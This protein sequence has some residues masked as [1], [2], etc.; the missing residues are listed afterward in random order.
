MAAFSRKLITRY[1]DGDG[2][3]PKLLTRNPV[4]LTISTVMAINIAGYLAGHGDDHDYRK[5]PL[6]PPNAVFLSTATSSGYI[7]NDAGG[8]R[9]VKWDPVVSEAHYFAGITP[10]EVRELPPITYPWE[11]EPGEDET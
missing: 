3:K 11:V 10:A 7:L 2:D 4:V 1:P 9:G 6:S 5:P 8:P